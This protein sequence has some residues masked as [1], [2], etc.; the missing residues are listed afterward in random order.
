M[1]KLL[2][3]KSDKPL[4]IIENE[5]KLIDECEQLEDELPPFF[6]SYYIFIRS[7]V[8]IKT[9]LAYLRDIKMFLEYLIESK[10]CPK[11]KVKDITLEDLKTVTAKTVNYYLD[12][13]RRY[14]KI[15]NGKEVVYTNENKSLARKKSALSVL[16]NFFYR[17]EMLDKNITLGFNPIKLPKATDREIKALTE[18]EV[19]KVLD[20]V[21]TGDGLTKKQ[22][23]YFNKTKKR[24]KAILLFFITFGLR[25]TELTQLNLS[26]FNYNRGEFEI[27]RKR[28]KQTTM[29]LNK[30]SHKALHEYIEE[31]RSKIEIKGHDK[32]ALFLS[33]QGKRLTERQ[34]RELVKKYTAIV[35]GTSVRKGYSPHKLRATT[36]TS[37]IE[38]GESIY[39]VQ[40][41]LNHENLQTTQLY[42]K[43]RNAA[44]KD[45]IKNFEWE[46]EFDK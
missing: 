42:S 16:F 41:L 45:L 21:M 7:N 32:D 43:H 37:L 38:R 5:A 8:L 39:D 31:E 40:A 18:D 13:L 26:S 6:S 15:E 2:H 34:I 35:L 29:P 19:Q 9:R 27:F 25:I 20:L 23:F 22:K 17:E 10:L 33:L 30:S 12:Y 44:K 24:D 36:A 46:E 28:N 11:P 14:K 4:N 1:E 3:N